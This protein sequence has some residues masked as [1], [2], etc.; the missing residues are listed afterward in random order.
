MEAVFLVQPWAQAR[1]ALDCCKPCY[2]EGW[3]K[4]HLG[5]KRAHLYARNA[6]IAVLKLEKGTN[7]EVSLQMVEEPREKCISTPQPDE[8]RH[9]KSQDCL[10]PTLN[11]YDR[12][13]ADYKKRL[14]NRSS[15]TPA[16]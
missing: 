1:A 8:Y 2:Q 12:I 11:V 13:L 10:Y 16:I 5:C 14:P 7:F 3:D 6:L 15:P 9:A 4:S